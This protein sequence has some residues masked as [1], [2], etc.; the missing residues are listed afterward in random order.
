MQGQGA[1]QGIKIR[2][3]GRVQALTAQFYVGAIFGVSCT[4]TVPGAASAASYTLPVEELSADLPVEGVFAS[5]PTS[6]T[7]TDLIGVIHA[8]R[9]VPGATILY[10]SQG[11]SGIG[12]E[13]GKEVEMSDFFADNIDFRSS[14]LFSPSTGS[15]YYPLANPSPDKTCLCP[16]SSS[17]GSWMRTEANDPN[18]VGQYDGLW[19]FAVA[20]PELPSDIDLVDV[21]FGAG[22]KMI[23]GVSVGEGPLEPMADLSESEQPQAFTFFQKLE[24][25]GWPYIPG[26]EFFARSPK[27]SLERNSSPNNIFTP[28]TG[29]V[30]AYISNNGIGLDE[31]QAEGSADYVIAADVAFA[32]DS[33]EVSG[34]GD[35]SVTEIVKRMKHDEPTEIKIEGYTDNVGDPGYNLELSEQR[36]QNVAEKLRQHF[37][38]VDLAI[39]G[40]GESSPVADNATEEGRAKNRRVVVSMEEK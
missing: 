24:G 1:G 25:N 27:L 18:S 39:K 2:D 32:F 40:Y 38:S 16:T 37:P 34:V 21:S 7:K 14:M 31:V 17:E 9:R 26:P 8:V 29:Q 28:L 3:E 4:L 22:R 35:G 30:K 11:W 19:T 33:A 6:G 5:T 36:A 13:I 23:Q 20:F 12:H 10:G 15:F